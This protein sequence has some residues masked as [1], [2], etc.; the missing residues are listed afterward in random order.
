M[1]LMKKETWTRSIKSIPILSLKL[2][3]AL[4]FF[5]VLTLRDPLIVQSSGDA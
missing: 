4:N 2:K 3:N 5:K 1:D